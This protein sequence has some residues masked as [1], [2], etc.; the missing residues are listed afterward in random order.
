MSRFV[1]LGHCPHCF[2]GTQATAYEELR[3]LEIMLSACIYQVDHTLE[4]FQP[5]VLR[6]RV[7]KTCQC[8][9]QILETKINR[10]TAPAVLC[11]VVQECLQ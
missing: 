3:T 11:L 4:P 5:S 7:F 9:Q 10:K 1:E 8:N 2:S 6:E